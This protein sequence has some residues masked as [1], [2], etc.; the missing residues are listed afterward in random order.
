MNPT[1]S[2]GTEYQV[3]ESR[4]LFLAIYPLACRAANV[5]SAAA[6]AVASVAPAD[7]KD[8]E[9]EA[10]TAVWLAL[11]RYDPSRASLRTF[12]ERVITTRFASLVRARRQRPKL[13]PLEEH[14]SVGLD[15]IP[16]VEFRTDFNRVSA[17]LAE[18]D[19]WLARFL[20]DHS[21]TEASRALRVSRST[22]YLGI[23]RIRTVFEVAGFGPQR[24]R[25]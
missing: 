20:V 25:P 2:A 3:N 8:W 4:A 17:S 11:P 19:R 7:R 10:L 1:P 5:R 14:H 16:G 15:G 21:P 18:C 13:E 9:Q 22:V 24:G 23:R 6:V 12:V